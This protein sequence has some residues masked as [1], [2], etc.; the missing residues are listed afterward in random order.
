[1]GIFLTLKLQWPIT[2]KNEMLVQAMLLSILFTESSSIGVRV[3][4][5][6]RASLERSQTVVHTKYGDVRVKVS[7]RC[8]ILRGH[9]C[10]SLIDWGHFKLF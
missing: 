2:I 1:M 8:Y 9:D 7:L 3:L 6:K 4:P 5:A 10:F